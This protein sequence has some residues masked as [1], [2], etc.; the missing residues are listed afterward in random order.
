LLERAA[1]LRERHF[2]DWGAG[3]VEIVRSE[4]SAT[5]AVHT[6]LATFPLVQLT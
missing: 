5:G 4:L 1:R 3:E 6:L 2:G